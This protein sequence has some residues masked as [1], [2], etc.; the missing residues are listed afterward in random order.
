MTPPNNPAPRNSNGFHRPASSDPGAEYHACVVG[1]AGHVGLPLAVVLAK[2][3]FRT[4][5]VDL[6]AAALERIS[7]GE[8]PFT[9]DGC[10][11]ML[12]EVL[13]DRMLG[14]TTNPAEVKGVPYV[15]L[16]IGTP[17]DEFHNPMLRVVTDCV[18]GLLPHLSDS[19]TVIL[20]STVFP[21]VT[22]FLHRYLRTHGRSPKLAFCPERVVQ[23]LAVKEIQTLPQIISGTT[24]EAEESA[25]RLFARIAPKLV[26][27]VPSEAEFSKLI[28]N[29]YRYIQFAAA[30]QF[31]MM[32]ESA[33][34]DFARVLEGLKA[35]YPRMRD[36]PRPGFAAGPCLYKDTLQLVAFNNNQFGLGHAAIQVN[37]GIPAYIVE[38]LARQRGGD[39]TGTTVGLL[40]MAFKSDSDDRRA[41]LSYKLKKLLKFRARD[42]LTTDPHVPDDRELLPAE[43]V[44]DRSD[45]LVLCTPHSA[46]RDLDLKGKPVVDIWNFLRRPA[47][48]KVVS[49][50]PS[51]L[52]APSP[53]NGCADPV[54]AIPVVPSVTAEAR[55]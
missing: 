22:D 50:S 29:A 48:A 4:L 40:G 3:G 35:D 10:E 46:Y 41:S 34:M 7:R 18:D 9:E 31:Y 43:T 37:E 45:A 39:L 52:G 5:V 24:P 51:L 38:R 49:I 8:V 25:S 2:R 26:R 14:F 19:Q 47:P 16:T 21:G 11:E 23:G 33:G 28:C 32:A 30:N 42:V 1:G 13:A 6:N 54:P 20:R 27:M 36:F 12:R 55:Q 15:V 53:A 17:V 44:V